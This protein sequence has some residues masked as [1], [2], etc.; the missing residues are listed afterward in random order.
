MRNTEVTDTRRGAVMLG[1]FPALAVPCGVTLFVL[2]VL[3]VSPLNP[4]NL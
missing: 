3:F 1:A 2:F 4:S